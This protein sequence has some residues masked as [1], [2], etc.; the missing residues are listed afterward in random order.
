MKKITLSLLLV[1]TIIAPALSQD[2]LNGIGKIRLGSNISILNEIGLGEP[3]VVDDWYNFVGTRESAIYIEQYDE[4]KNKESR[5]DFSI[6]VFIPKFEV[7]EGVF[8]LDV[9]LSFYDN[10]LWNIESIYLNQEFLELLAL[11]YG[12]PEL[13]SVTEDKYYTNRLTGATIVK[14]DY[15]HTRIYTTNDQNIECYSELSKKHDSKGEARMNAQ[16]VLRDKSVYNTIDALWGEYQERQSQR[17]LEER[18]SLLEQ[19]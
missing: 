3:I 7:V 16:F 19:L 4:N 5:F 17:K 15:T 13:S 18:K 1:L 12:E 11:K 14:T 2:V 9:I 8:I 6:S 10:Q